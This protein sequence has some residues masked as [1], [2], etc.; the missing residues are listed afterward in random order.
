MKLR[1]IEFGPVWGASG[2][3]GFFGE[4][5]KFHAMWK[6]LGLNFHN[7]TFAGKSTTL[8]PN[9]GIW[10]PKCI[11]VKFQHGLVLNAVGLKGPG[12]KANLEKGSWQKRTNPFLISFGTLAKTQDERLTELAQFS[13]LL[14]R[15]LQYFQA[16]VALQLD[17]CPNVDIFRTEKDII[18]ESYI[19]LTVVNNILESVPLIPKFDLTIS[20]QA[21]QKISC[22]PQCDA[23][24]MTNAIPWGT[25]QESIH[26]GK[27][28]GSS[29]SP[30]ARLGGGAL[31]GKPLFR[32][33]VAY[34]TELQ[35]IGF[36]KPLNV[37]GGIL[38][39]KDGETIIQL[40]L[41][42]LPP[43]AVS[44]FV[45]SVALLRPWNVPRIIQTA[46]RLL[47]Q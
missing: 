34:I 46:H 15:H 9:L 17:S 24:V 42:F 25:L 35:K 2:V 21:I 30:L 8:H 7:M 13:E 38:C 5:Y 32:P 43:E 20:P 3:Q 19:A 12:L 36:K 23:I 37:G 33:L 45:G 29:V 27:L 40:L 47:P 4:G 41:K 31:S 44:V 11:R 16:P 10:F 18:S 22:H 1:G 14:K 6:L 26:W 39:P 28:F